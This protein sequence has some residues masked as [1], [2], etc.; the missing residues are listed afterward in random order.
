MP[1]LVLHSWLRDV[2]RRSKGV[3]LVVR[4]DTPAAHVVDEDVV[5]PVVR[6]QALV[7]PLDALAAL[8][9]LD[10][11]LLLRHHA[12]EAKCRSS[13][14]EPTRRPER[15][16]GMFPRVLLPWLLLAAVGCSS[17]EA[18]LKV[19]TEHGTASRGIVDVGDGS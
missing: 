13:P 2:R 6:V 15:R 14:R 4:H 5:V 12:T 18:A 7:A 16:S 10:R 9:A 8:R 11:V 17:E 19:R 3:A 1:L